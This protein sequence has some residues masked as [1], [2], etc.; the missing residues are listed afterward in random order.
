[1]NRLHFHP[2]FKHAAE[3]QRELIHDWL[4]QDYIR[5]WIHGQGLKNTLEGLEKFLQ[6][7]AEGKA[8]N[9]QSQITHHWIG[10]DNEKPFVYLLTSN[11]SKKATDVYAKYSEAE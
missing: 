11:V 10:Y 3:S 8:L 4:Q 7:Q 9:Y 2:T 6:E 5:E 1:M